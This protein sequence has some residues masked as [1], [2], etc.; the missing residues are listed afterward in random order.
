MVNDNVQKAKKKGF[1]PLRLH[2]DA[3]EKL[4]YICHVTGKT[5]VAQ[6]DELINPVYQVLV[7]FKNANLEFE[8]SM[9]Q[10]T[11]LITASGR[12]RVINGSFEISKD[13]DK[14]EANMRLKNQLEA[15]IK[16]KKGVTA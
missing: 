3:V 11:V 15:Q 16:A 4:D 6:F 2:A 5:K 12:S 13:A 1:N 7:N 10:N 9:L 14:A 8:T